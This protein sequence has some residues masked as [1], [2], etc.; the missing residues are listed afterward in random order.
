MNYTIYNFDWK[1]YI[2]E[3]DDLRNIGI[4]NKENAWKHWI[5]YGSKENRRNRM[6]NV[7][8]LELNDT[9][10]L[11]NSTDIKISKLYFVCRYNNSSDFIIAS[12]LK[13]SISAFDCNI[14]YDSELISVVFNSNDI[15]VFMIDVIN[16]ENIDISNFNC[17]KIA[18]VISHERKSIQFLK[19]FDYVFCLTNKAKIFIES[20]GVKAYILPI[21]GTFK[22]Y[23]F[24]TEYEY[25]ILID[26][27]LFHNREIINYA[28]YLIKLKKYK[29]KIVGKG[30]DIFL[31]NDEFNVIENYY[32]GVVLYDEINDLYLK[33]R[34]IID[35]CS[36][37]KK[38]FGSLNKRVIDVITCKRIILTN[39]KVG[40][41]EFFDNTLPYYDSFDTLEKNIDLY[42][43]NSSL[44]NEKVN[45]LYSYS[46]KFINNDNYR[47]VF[48]N[49]ELFQKNNI[50]CDLL[51][52]ICGKVQPNFTFTESYK[53]KD[54]YIAGNIKKQLY[55]LY[56]LNCQIL[57]INDWYNYK[58][59]NCIN[60]MFLHGIYNY[61]PI[62]KNN[63]IMVFVSHTDT[64]SLDEFNKY[65]KVICCCEIL[66]E[67]IK[68]NLTLTNDNLLFALYDVFLSNENNFNIF[69]NKKETHFL[70]KTY[71]NENYE[72]K[73]DMKVINENK[74][75][76]YN[77]IY[78]F[79]VF[80]VTDSMD[81]KYYSFTKHQIDIFDK[82]L[83]IIINENKPKIFNIPPFKF[84]DVSIVKN[85]KVFTMVKNEI[86]ILPYF[87]K[88]YSHLFG[89]ENIH[90]I[91]NM[92]DDG[93]YEYLQNIKI[94]NKSFNLIQTPPDFNFINKHVFLNEQINNYKDKCKFVLILD[95]DEFIIS[96]DENIEG[97]F[98][99]LN[100]KKSDNLVVRMPDYLCVDYNDNFIEN[101]IFIDDDNLGIR[102]NYAKC[103]FTNTSF[104]GITDN[105]NHNFYIKEYLITK[106]R[107]LHFHNR[108][109]NIS[110]SKKHN[111]LKSYYSNYDIEKLNRTIK[112]FKARHV[113]KELLD[114]V[115]N[116]DN[117]KFSN[118]LFVIE[119]RMLVNFFAPILNSHIHNNVMIS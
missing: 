33:S 96:Q 14:I 39:N 88:W 115:I 8:D 74:K 10:E 60:I 6:L 82:R 91:D 80:N 17:T 1:Y 97:Q 25:D 11:N 46:M 13:Y 18:W 51:I 69:L 114:F 36:I 118:K 28:I 86:D 48:T 34:I 57:L 119:K 98:S 61:N 19:L 93:T 30:W 38:E 62:S 21:G 45:E 75:Q 41:L 81:K 95:A 53:W 4:L 24:S 49:L 104:K 94:Q 84:D 40:N 66:H 27:N 83:S 22:K 107:I 73:Y 32:G 58:M 29:I 59:Y 112:G 56:G 70:I 68:V 55:L 15:V 26:I 43:N 20:T 102:N 47:H 113:A 85:T 111:L 71:F 2:E 108:S 72:S 64:Y 31:S 99:M 101:N 65:N 52:K 9:T 42:I 100:S 35:D 109:I 12:D 77:F 78:S 103:M 54:L 76:V 5:L 67:K 16:I 3:Y 7:K 92:S 23:K 89:I 90:I 79:L 106:L 105:G 117:F 116:K 44:Y 50:E 37:D 87:I 63:N 110:I